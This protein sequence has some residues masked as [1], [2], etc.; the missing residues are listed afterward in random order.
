[1]RNV[2]DFPFYV[3]VSNYETPI[4]VVS[5]ELNTLGM[6]I[7]CNAAAV[8]LLGYT[9]EEMKSIHINDLIP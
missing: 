3:L 2:V 1:M 4:F 6:I 9:M 8:S 5:A 7:H